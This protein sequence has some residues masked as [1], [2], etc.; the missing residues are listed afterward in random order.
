M[1]D[2]VQMVTITK[3][4]YEALLDDSNWVQCLEMAGVS[5]WDGIEIAQE[6][7]NEDED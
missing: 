5:D 2:Q 3:K 1:T 4:E 7:F 6:M